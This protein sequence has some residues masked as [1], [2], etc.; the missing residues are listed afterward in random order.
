[1]NAKEYEDKMETL[2]EDHE[3]YTKIETDPAY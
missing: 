1:M 2:L 3:T